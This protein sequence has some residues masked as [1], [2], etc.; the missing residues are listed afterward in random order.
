[1]DDLRCSFLS[2]VSCTDWPGRDPRIWMAYHL[3]SPELDH[4]VRNNLSINGI[5]LKVRREIGAA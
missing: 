5:A 1:V 3:R 4:R 2:D